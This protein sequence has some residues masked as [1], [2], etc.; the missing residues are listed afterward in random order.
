M[1]APTQPSHSREG[2]SQV[3]SVDPSIPHLSQAIF[4]SSTFKTENGKCTELYI[5]FK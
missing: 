4:K 3:W 2:E 1:K 5:L